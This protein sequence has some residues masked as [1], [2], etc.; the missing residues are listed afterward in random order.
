MEQIQPLVCKDPNLTGRLE[1]LLQCSPFPQ[2]YVWISGWLFHKK[3]EDLSGLKVAVPGGPF[4][5]PF[6]RQVGEQ[7][8]TEP[9]RS[10]FCARLVVPNRRENRD[11]LSLNFTVD[12]KN[13]RKIRGTFKGLPNRDVDTESSLEKP[14][15]LVSRHANSC[16]VEI[17]RLALETFFASDQTL[18]FREWKK[19][20]LSI[21]IVL[22]N[23]AELTLNCLRSL[24]SKIPFELILVDNASTDRTADLLRRIR[25]AAIVRNRKNNHFIRG[26]NRGAQKARGKYL[27][28]LN[29]DCTVLPSSLERAL[30]V[31][32]ENKKAGVVGA[33]IIHPDATLQHAG[34]LVWRDASTE[35]YGEGDAADSF[36]YLFQRD[37]PYCTGAF[38]L[39]PNRL[40]RELGGFSTELDKAYYEDVDYCLTV[41]ETGRAVIYDPDVLVTHFK[42][43]SW[44]ADNDSPDFARTV[45]QNQLRTL[46]SHAKYFMDRPQAFD[47]SRKM[48]RR[49]ISLKEIL[50]V[51]NELPLKERSSNVVRLVEAALK[52]NWGVTLFPLS[53][54]NMGRKEAYRYLPRQVEIVT[55]FA[56][57]QPL[58]MPSLRELISERVGYYRYCLASDSASSAELKYARETL[59][60]GDR[61]YFKWLR[62]LH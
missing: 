54:R 39:T 6:V 47:S 43:A 25:G 20:L 56:G 58:P 35:E 60:A 36:P 14:S 42:N 52:K 8:K 33:R 13:G 40:F 4:I 31:M 46:R 11:L 7:K 22:Y 44:T 2:S 34:G 27:L 37:V 1:M 19:P 59:S 30:E 10:S 12:L 45:H 61:R 15:Y 38:L 16:S 53:A 23:R 62:D 48:G 55:E 51:C 18:E 21:V 17:C 9:N 24:T 5:R 3:G 28:F 29:N 32:K 26:A 41:R 57:C 49:G 50:I